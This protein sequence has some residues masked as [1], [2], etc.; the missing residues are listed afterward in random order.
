MNAN[1][2]KVLDKIWNDNKKDLQDV[3]QLN[4]IEEL[5]YYHLIPD[6]TVF[7]NSLPEGTERSNYIWCECGSALSPYEHG[8]CVSCRVF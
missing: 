2:E 6:W 4:W 1:I 7:K 5:M 8:V 3:P